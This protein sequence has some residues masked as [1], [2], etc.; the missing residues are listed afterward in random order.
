M[1]LRFTAGIFSFF[2][3]IMLGCRPSTPNRINK[4][5]SV[6]SISKLPENPLEMTPMA[7]SLQ[8]EIK[9]MAALYG[10][11]MA[12]KRLKDGADYAAGSVLYL[13]TW[14]GKADPDWFGARIPE[15]VAAIERVSI[16]Q[17]GQKS[18][19]FFKGPA[20]YSGLN[21]KNDERQNIMLSMPLAGSP[22]AK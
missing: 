18:Y 11:G 8:P 6:S 5:A 13:V 1:K 20:W 19:T 12:A 3:F 15:Q 10:N 9:T 21:F 16:D 14:K 17:N 22:E 4:E 7:V 2:I